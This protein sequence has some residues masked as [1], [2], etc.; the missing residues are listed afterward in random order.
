MVVVKLTDPSRL[1][2]QA[3]HR[4]R[5]RRQSAR[6]RWLHFDRRMH[7]AEIVVNQKQRRRFREKTKRS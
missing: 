5:F 1:G 4:P 3:L 6:L 7:A 2:K